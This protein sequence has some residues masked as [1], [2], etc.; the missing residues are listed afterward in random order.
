MRL[1]SILAVCLLQVAASMHISEERGSRYQ[2][3]SEILTAKRNVCRLF[4]PTSRSCRALE[5]L[6]GTQCKGSESVAPEARPAHGHDQG[7]VELVQVD[8][9]ES[10]EQH[11]DT[12]SA[13]LTKALF[14]EEK[15]T[16]LVQTVRAHKL[17]HHAL[18]DISSSMSALEQAT[19]RLEA[20]N[21]DTRQLFVPQGP[22]GELADARTGKRVGNMIRKLGDSEEDPR[23]NAGAG[24]HS[25]MRSATMAVTALLGDTNQSANTGE[26]AC[27]PKVLDTIGSSPACVSPDSQLLDCRHQQHLLVIRTAPQL[28]W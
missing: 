1:M 5:R 10:S 18:V 26:K 20:E 28:N 14:H 25:A 3:C 6:H 24:E 21:L 13:R 4:L 11:D 12:D 8:A 7:A 9:H 19:F 2:D 15:A 22:I 27:A 16:K 23:K 17:S